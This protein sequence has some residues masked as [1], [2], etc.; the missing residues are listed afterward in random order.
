MNSKSEPFSQITQRILQTGNLYLEFMGTVMEAGWA[1]FAGEGGDDTRA[2]IHNNLSRHLLELYQQSVGKYLE[3]PQLGISREAQQQFN[4]AISAY[5]EFLVETGGFLATFS[6]PLKNAMDLLQQS[7]KDREGTDGEFKSAKEVYNFAVKVLDKEYDDWLK[8]PEGVQR[9]ASAVDKYLDY[10]KKLNPVRDNWYK[11]L[12]IPTR[13]EMED[14]YKG[15]YD[16]KKKSRQQDAVIRRQ[17]DSIKKLNSK[18]RKLEM[19]LAE[20]LP[21]K[22]TAASRSVPNER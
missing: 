9:V 6:T 8:S 11:S 13:S 15:I 19:S 12:S 7:I 4:T 18:I 1:A 5:H 16:L 10:R 3:A 17:S 22:E 14:V 21:R 2:K 20:S